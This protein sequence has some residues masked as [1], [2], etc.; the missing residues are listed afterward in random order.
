MTGWAMMVLPTAGSFPGGLWPQSPP[1]GQASQSCS[2]DN[3]NGPEMGCPWDPLSSPDRLI[4]STQFLPLPPPHQ[5]A[6]DRKSEPLAQDTALCRGGDCICGRVGSTGPISPP[7]G[8]TSPSACSPCP[9]ARTLRV[10]HP[11]LLLMWP[12]VWFAHSGDPR[13]RRRH[14]FFVCLLFCL[15]EFPQPGPSGS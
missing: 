5:R 10:P 4:C 13:L 9:L 8:H 14:S 7:P 12:L 11:P 2:A 1:T 3:G 6:T 15:H